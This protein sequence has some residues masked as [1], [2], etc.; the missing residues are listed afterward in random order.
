[1]AGYFYSGSAPPNDMI[2]V[3]VSARGWEDNIPLGVVAV[4]LRRS[5]INL[6]GATRD[7]D[8]REVAIRSGLFF[9]GRRTN[10]R[11]GLDFIIMPL[12][13]SCPQLRTTWSRRTRTMSMMTAALRRGL[14]E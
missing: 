7:Q 6:K 10:G 13:I 5:F 14:W 1:M 3:V 2:S 11:R 9:R 8:V 12:V 4:Y